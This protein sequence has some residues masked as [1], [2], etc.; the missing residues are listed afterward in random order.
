VTIGENVT[1]G[2]SAVDHG[3]TVGD[4]CL[5]GMNSTV[6][7]GAIIGCSSIVGAGSLVLSGKKFEQRSLL[8]GVPA[9]LLRQVTDDEA[10]GIVE[11]S[12]HYVDL[13]HKYIKAL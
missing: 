5:I 1:I 6:L 10:K 11:A 13:S 12:L 9:K 4:G 2:H 7:D 8:G 3:C